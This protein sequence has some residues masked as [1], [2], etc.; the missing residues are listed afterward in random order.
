MTVSTR[1][2][3]LKST[4]IQ[5]AL[6]VATKEFPP[7]MSPAKFGELI[8]ISTNTVYEWIAKGRLESAFRKRGKHVLIWRDRALAIVYNGPDWR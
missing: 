2:K 7:I 3:P 4:E 5:A 6:S 8:G 1:Q